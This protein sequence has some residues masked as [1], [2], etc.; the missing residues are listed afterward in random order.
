MQYLPRAHLFQ[1]LWER[2]ANLLQVLVGVRCSEETGKAFLD[3]NTLLAQMKV[4]HARQL[5]VGGNREVEP[6]REGLKLRRVRELAQ[7]RIQIRDQRSSLGGE[8]GLQL[9]S[10]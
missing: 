3:V 7:H 5:W 4:Q 9:R 2:I 6:G 10:G 8:V 1:T